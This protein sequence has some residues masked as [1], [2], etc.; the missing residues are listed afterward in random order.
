MNSFY[1]KEIASKSHLSLSKKKRI[2]GELIQIEKELIKPYQKNREDK[3]QK[4]VNSERNNP[5]YF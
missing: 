3:E 5:M 1:H 2:Q 4:S